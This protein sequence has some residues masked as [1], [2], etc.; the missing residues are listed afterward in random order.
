MIYCH[1]D[2]CST[3]HLFN[4]KTMM[5]I[6]ES[7][8]TLYHIRSIKISVLFSHRPTS[9]SR[10]DLVPSVRI[11][12]NLILLIEYCKTKITEAASMSLFPLSPLFCSE[13][14]TARAGHGGASL[15]FTQ[16]QGKYT[17]NEKE[18]LCPYKKILTLTSRN[19]CDIFPLL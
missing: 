11:K 3:I 7:L 15:P 17:S 5:T 4:T 1:R 9:Y 16:I 13:Q 8:Q 2:L 6:L 14:H 18:G 10:P 19:E 12:N